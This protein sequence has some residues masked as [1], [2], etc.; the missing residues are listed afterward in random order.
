MKNAKGRRVPCFAK[1]PH[2]ACPS[3]RPDNPKLEHT[4]DDLVNRAHCLTPA[5]TDVKP[6]G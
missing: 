1:P 2:P 4:L 5:E 3:P 6:A